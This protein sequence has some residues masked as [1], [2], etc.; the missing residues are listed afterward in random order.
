M[1]DG[2]YKLDGDLIYGPNFVYNKDY[3]L[4]KENKDTYSY[5]IDGWYGLIL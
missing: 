2:F 1:K 4:L 5:P 3:E